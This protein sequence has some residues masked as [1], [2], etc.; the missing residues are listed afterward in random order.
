MIKNFKKLF[1]ISLSALN[2]LAL[3]PH[4][5]CDEF[6]P[7]PFAFSNTI[8][9]VKISFQLYNF[10]KPSTFNDYIVSREDIES[11]RINIIRDGMVSVILSY[12]NGHKR[13]FYFN[14]LQSS[15]NRSGTFKISRGIRS[16]NFYVAQ[17]LDIPPISEKDI[18]GLL[19]L[20]EKTNLIVKESFE[21]IENVDLIGIPS[22]TKIKELSHNPET[23]IVIQ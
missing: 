14:I 1:I 15:L 2:L 7:H 20:P 4:A 11:A 3:A 13:E 19:V 10:I 8:H 21:N 12:R 16:F 18:R 9:H 6:P 23:K 22:H 17:P 5:F